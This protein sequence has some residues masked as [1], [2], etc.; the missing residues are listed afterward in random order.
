MPQRHHRRKLSS[1]RTVPLNCKK[2]LLS[3]LRNK[4]KS[5]SSNNLWSS[6]KVSVKVRIYFQWNPWAFRQISRRKLRH[7]KSNTSQETW[8]ATS[9]VQA[10]EAHQPKSSL[11]ARSNQPGQTITKRKL[12]A[13]QPSPRLM[14]AG[15][16]ARALSHKRRRVRKLSNHRSRSPRQSTSRRLRPCPQPLKTTIQSRERSW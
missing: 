7:Q 15:S 12:L 16:K 1:P 11:T 6:S 14:Y 3:I 10:V 13:N 4:S 9:A 2:H 8:A 5:R